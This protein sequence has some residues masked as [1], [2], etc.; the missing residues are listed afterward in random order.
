MF[1][2]EGPRMKN[3]VLQC[4]NLCATIQY[5][6]TEIHVW[7]YTDLVAVYQ[8]GITIVSEVCIKINISL[9]KD[10]VYSVKTTILDKSSVQPSARQ[11]FHHTCTIKGD[12]LVLEIPDKQI[13]SSVLNTK[14]SCLYALCIDYSQN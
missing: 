8:L 13:D 7:Y 2:D 4:V 12:K 1:H 3:T 5:L 9:N 11:E 10:A 6:I 14:I